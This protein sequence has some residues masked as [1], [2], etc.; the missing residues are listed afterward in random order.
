MKLDS[1]YNICLT[2]KL[3]QDEILVFLEEDLVFTDEKFVPFE[4]Q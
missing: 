1:D 2:G 4:N 3:L